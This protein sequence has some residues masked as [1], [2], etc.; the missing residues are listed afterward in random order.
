MLLNTVPQNDNL[1]VC[2]RIVKGQCMDQRP[3]P[4]QNSHLRTSRGVGS[5]LDS[6]RRRGTNLGVVNVGSIEGRLEMRAAEMEKS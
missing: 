5:E 3:E 2:G 6:R 4:M 1:L